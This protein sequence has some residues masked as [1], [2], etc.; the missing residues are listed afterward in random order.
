MALRNMTIVAACAAMIAVAP[1]Q[2]TMPP[3]RCG[4]IHVSG[5][6][7]VVSTHLLQCGFARK[8]A[9]KYLRNGRH[10]KKWSCT[11]YDP[12]ETRIA[13]ICRNGTYTYYAV[14]R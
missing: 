13:F 14:R 8:Q 12:S 4:A 11:S 10:G 5:K 9:K 2:A 6:A 3:T 1:A 7:Y